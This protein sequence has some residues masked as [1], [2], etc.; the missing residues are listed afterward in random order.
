MGQNLSEWLRT[1]GAVLLGFLLASVWQVW[2]DWRQDSRKRRSAVAALKSRVSNDVFFTQKV[3][4]GLRGKD[5]PPPKALHKLAFFPEPGARTIEH[6][7]LLK[8][9]II[10]GLDH[11]EKAVLGAKR[12]RD[13]EMME[14]L[15]A[16][17]AI[18]RKRIAIVVTCFEAFVGV[19]R[20]FLCE[21]DREHPDVV[22]PREPQLGSSYKVHLD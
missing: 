13:T 19:G 17:E 4:D 18:G 11:Y 2:R 12:S 10:L 9:N 15:A 1:L 7:G 20:D 16:D 3:V 22:V 6:L 14:P 21:L 8:P 5:G